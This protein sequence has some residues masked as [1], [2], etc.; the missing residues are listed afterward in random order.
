VSWRYSKD[1][2]SLKQRRALL[3]REDWV[4][5]LLNKITDNLQIGFDEN[6][7]QQFK[8]RRLLEFVE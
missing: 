3:C 1:H 5:N 8:I 4:A 7:K 6:K 2:D